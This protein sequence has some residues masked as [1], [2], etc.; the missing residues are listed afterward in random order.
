MEDSPQLDLLSY[1]L[2]TITFYFHLQ[3]AIANPMG[4]THLK[5]PHNITLCIR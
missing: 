4:N 2:Y 5:P 1:S 3:P